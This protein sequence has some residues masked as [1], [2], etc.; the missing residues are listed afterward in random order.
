[1][2]KQTLDFYKSLLDNLYDG[3]YFVDTD[4]RITYWNRGAERITGYKAE[5]VL[6]H[7]CRDNILNH[8]SENGKELC[9]TDCPLIKSI[10]EHREME[11][12][13]F[14]HH[15]DGHRVPIL[16]RTSPIVEDG[17]T[18]GAVEI[19]S[20]SS[21]LL[22]A[23]QQASLLEN[24][25]FQDPLTGVANRRSGES[26]LQAAMMEFTQ[27]G[28]P[29][30]IVFLDIDYFKRVNDTLGHDIGDQVLR[31]LAQTL[32]VNLRQHDMVC[33]WG[34]EE[35]VLLIR[36]VDEKHLKKISEKLR[37]LINQAGLKTEAEQVS[38]T[39][40]MGA[41]LA[42]AG[43]NLKKI[44]RRADALMYE[45]KQSGRNRVTMG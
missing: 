11:A 33:R 2:T 29:F 43:D 8:C 21:Q 18:I 40:S 38:I 36:D 35:F 20:D 4:R 14:L 31:M 42:R 12:E 30:G 25:A 19:F 34:G 45:S 15:A 24:I 17:K 3:I 28:Q 37:L 23:R 32:K 5:Q 26:R 9:K 27:V 39:V 22:N 13:V 1:V 16:V 41:T 44:T 6:G 10:T 7:F